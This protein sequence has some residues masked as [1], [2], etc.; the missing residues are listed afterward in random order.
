MSKY[1]ILWDHIIDDSRLL[2][3]SIQKTGKTYKGIVTVARGGLGVVAVISRILKVKLIDVMCLQSYTDSHEQ[4]HLT[5]IKEATLA[6][7]DGG[8]GWLVVDDLLDSGCTYH[9][10]KRAL[11]KADFVCL[12]NKNS[13]FAANNDYLFA[14]QMKAD[15]WIVFPW[16]V[17]EE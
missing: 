16:E 1:M 8:E 6:M 2:A 3:E 10:I 17:V 11:P 7:A 13:E 9:Y 4:E 15:Q 5:V 14:K 12:Y